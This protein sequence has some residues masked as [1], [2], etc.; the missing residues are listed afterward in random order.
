MG[1]PIPWNHKFSGNKCTN[2]EYLCTSDLSFVYLWNLGMILQ[3]YKEGNIIHIRPFESL[4]WCQIILHFFILRCMWSKKKFLCTPKPN[5]PVLNLK[6]MFLKI[7]RKL[8][9]CLCK[10]D[11]ARHMSDFWTADAKF[12]KSKPKNNLSLKSSFAF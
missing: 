5:S 1:L 2:S 4:F 11:F 10:Q 7:F 6:L 3:T 9:N 12:W 8:T